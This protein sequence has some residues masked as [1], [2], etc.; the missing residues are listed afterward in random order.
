M[1][2]AAGH[3][4]DLL[5]YAGRRRG[6]DRRDAATV[7]DLAASP[8]DLGLPVGLDVRW[9]GVA[10]F[11]LTYEGTTVVIDPYVSRA[12]LG[13]LLRRRVVTSDPV[14]LDRWIPKAD[15]V[16]LGHTH[17][18]HAVDAPAL[19]RRDGC[20]VYGGRSARHLLALHGL[21]EQAVEVEAHRTYEMGPFA[22]TFVPSA[23][24]KLFLGRSVPNGGE[25]TCEHVGELSSARYQCGQVWGIHVAVAGSTLYHQGSADLLDDQ[26]RHRD[27]DVFLCGVAGRQFTPDYLLRVLG[28]LRPQTVVVTHH[29]D[30]LTPLGG[31]L[32]FAFGVDVARLPDEVAAVS[33][34]PRVVTL[35]DPRPLAPSAPPVG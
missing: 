18:D 29:D 6:H 28:L 9:L 24:A 12:P 2:S 19:A 11:A 30:F 25:I 22:V 34:Q 31:D 7:A 13:D 15:A 3:L 23:H 20:H 1:T 8:A 21:A 5:A 16:L 14:L 33:R 27:V 26:V 10:G 32:G 17:F 4:A 35:P